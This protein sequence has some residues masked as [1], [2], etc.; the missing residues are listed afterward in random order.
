MYPSAPGWQPYPQYAPKPPPVNGLS[1]A[2]LVVGI[3]CCV[4]PLGLVFGLIA[5]GQIKRKGQRGTGMAIAGSILSAISTV[6]VVTSIAT[7][8]AGDAWDGF[9]KG[10]DDAS[11]SRSTLDLRTGDCFRVPGEELE[12]DTERVTIVDCELRHDA[13][14][15]GGFSLGESESEFDS[16]SGSGFQDWPG[17]AAV[18][19]I[20]EER[21]QKIND[22]Y[23]GSA[24]DLPAGAQLYYYMPSARSWRLGDETVTC[25]I[26]DPDG[27]LKGSVRAD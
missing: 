6:L 1:I 18:E 20:A 22:R 12:A 11:R 25:A 19:P 10:M 8:W 7:G 24:S 13:E 26:A 5:L 9:R 16:G 23:T 15:T 4:P 2:S 17:E 14:V 3:V 27:R 21:C